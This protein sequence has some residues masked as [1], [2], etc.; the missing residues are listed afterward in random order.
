MTYQGS[1]LP[2][3]VRA[4]RVRASLQVLAVRRPRSSLLPND[5]ERRL[6]AELAGPSLNGSQTYR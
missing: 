5:S 2:S 3:D 1:P 4:G 6:G